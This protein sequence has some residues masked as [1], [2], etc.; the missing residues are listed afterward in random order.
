MEYDRTTAVEVTIDG[1]NYAFLP[2]CVFDDIPVGIE[3]KE[4]KY[5]AI[6][7]KFGLRDMFASKTV[8]EIT[9]MKK[10]MLA[11]IKYGI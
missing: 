5:E 3:A 2:I 4:F 1:K 7:T 10:Y 11:K 8:Y 9:D 6:E